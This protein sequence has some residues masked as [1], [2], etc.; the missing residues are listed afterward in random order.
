MTLPPSHFLSHKKSKHK[1]SVLLGSRLTRLLKDVLFF[2]FFSLLSCNN[3]Q[4]VWS[5]CVAS[6]TIS[7]SNIF[8]FLSCTP[9][10]SPPLSSGNLVA[11]CLRTEF[12]S[13]TAAG[14][15]GDQCCFFFYRVTFV[16]VQETRQRKKNR[17]LFDYSPPLW[18]LKRGSFVWT[19]DRNKLDSGKCSDNWYAL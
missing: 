19:S 17:E 1:H 6:H 18:P 12:L 8:V 9:A 5:A 14:L 2:F 15:S 16:N 11:T 3:G 7:L 4:G 10:C 13:S